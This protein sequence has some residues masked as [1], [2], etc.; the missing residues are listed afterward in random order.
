MISST[1]SITTAHLQ[2]CDAAAGCDREGAASE[3]P[4]SNIERAGCAEVRHP[5]GMIGSLIYGK[6]LGQ[7]KTGH[8]VDVATNIESSGQ[9]HTLCSTMTMIVCI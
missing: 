5:W 2:V 3:A 8:L 1:I 9:S 6:L 7:V 4:H